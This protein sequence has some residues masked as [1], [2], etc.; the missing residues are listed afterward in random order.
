VNINI[1]RP[2]PRGILTSVR[3]D[4]DPARIL[5]ELSTNVI[6]LKND[7]GRRLEAVEADIDRLTN[8][9]A[10]QIAS[11]GGD[12]SAPPAPAIEGFPQ[13]VSSAR[14]ARRSPIDA[15]ALKQGRG[16][17]GKF[18]RAGLAGLDVNAMSVGSN[19]DGGY[20]V[21]PVISTII[22]QKLFDQTAMRQ[23]ARIETIS[24]GDR[25]EEPN[26][27]S[28]VDAVWVGEQTPRTQTAGPSLGKL[29][30]SVNEEYALIPVTQ[31]LLD[32]SDYDIG[33]Y[34]EGKVA[35][36][37]GRT[38]GT[39]YISGDGIEKPRGFLTMNVSTEKDGV[40]PVGTIQ[41]VAT[42]ASGGFKIGD[43][44]PD[45]ADCLKSLVWSLRAPYRKGAVFLMNS[46]TASQVDQLKDGM[47]QYL[48]RTSMIADAPPTLLGYPV[49]ID[50]TAMPDIGANSF[51]IAFGN[52]QKA[53]IIVDKVQGTMLLRDPFTSKPNVLFFWYRR[54][55]GAVQNSEA[56]KLLKFATS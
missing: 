17:L 40:R 3:G 13:I 21:D 12:F 54:T 7:Q 23:L 2:M 39:A 37:F 32:D 41:Y 53:Y 4:A 45:S 14:A 6:A 9:R 33:A 29:S 27:F 52:F 19:P 46:A 34:L 42:G 30:V 44:P 5:A 48:W 51:A 24:A 36:K 8:A 47:G 18:A 11:I 28:D 25:F 31:R 15:R 35:D 49:V 43:S 56:V 38:E 1:A 55:G 16:A 26:D 22:N 10:A 50:D 20:T